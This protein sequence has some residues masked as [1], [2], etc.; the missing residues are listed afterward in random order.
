[1]FRDIEVAY[2][3]ASEDLG[4]PIIPCGEAFQDAIA[5]G[6]GK[7]HRDT[8]HASLGIGRY[9]LGGVWYQTLTGNSMTENTFS[10]FDEDVTKDDIEIAKKSVFELLGRYR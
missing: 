5:K 7:L 3:K 4:I 6:I 8:F 2:K 10:D 9:I 1:M